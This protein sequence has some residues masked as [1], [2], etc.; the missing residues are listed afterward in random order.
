MIIDEWLIIW[1]KEGH[2][3]FLYRKYIIS[4]KNLC[5]ML[6]ITKN[7][8][9]SQILRLAMCAAISIPSYW[10]PFYISYE[11]AEYDHRM[12]FMIFFFGFP[13][14]ITATY[15]SISILNKLMSGLKSVRAKWRCIVCFVG[16]ILATPSILAVFILIVSTVLNL[17]SL[18][19]YICREL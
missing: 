3:W 18:L 7:Q 4:S 11:F 17:L 1:W 9:L 16:V 2:F 8:H 10:Y 19:I 15:F 6:T 5:G 13:F 12:G 14:L